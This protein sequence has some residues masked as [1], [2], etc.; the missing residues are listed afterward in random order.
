MLC[1][2]CNTSAFSPTEIVTNGIDNNLSVSCKTYPD[3]CHG[4][5]KKSIPLVLFRCLCT[6][7]AALVSSFVC[8]IFT[9]ISRLFATLRKFLFNL[10]KVILGLASIFRCPN[11]F[12]LGP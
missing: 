11:R 3:F 9:F 4:P 1:K 5:G 8:I 7:V 12:I 2:P 6:V 10:S